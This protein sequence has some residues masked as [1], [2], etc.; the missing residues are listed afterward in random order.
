MADGPISNGLRESEREEYY[1]L[2]DT[3]DHELHYVI[4]EF[5]CKLRNHFFYSR[6][7]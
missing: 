1:L 7:N 2:H 4:D 3:E 5:T 6:M